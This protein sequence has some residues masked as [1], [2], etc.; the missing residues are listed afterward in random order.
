MEMSYSYAK[1]KQF[2]DAGDNVLMWNYEPLPTTG[3]G[4]DYRS[5]F[6]KP[7]NID[8]EENEENVEEEKNVKEELSDVLLMNTEKYSRTMDID[9]HLNDTKR[10]HLMENPTEEYMQVIHENPYVN[11]DLTIE[12]MDKLDNEE[13]KKENYE[14]ENFE[15][16][17][18]EI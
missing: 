11:P 1:T 15:E 13:E 5:T 17:E 14:D 9:S 12:D 3:L 6:W 8:E 18:N 4:M 10:K 16:D 7:L 2:N